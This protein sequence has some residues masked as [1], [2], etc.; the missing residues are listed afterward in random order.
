MKMKGGEGVKANY[1]IKPTREQALS[2]DRT[3]PRAR[4]IAAL[5]VFGEFG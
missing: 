1:A 4:F 3:M 2:T 5:G